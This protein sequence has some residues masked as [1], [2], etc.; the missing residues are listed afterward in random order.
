VFKMIRT[1]A[2]M[3]SIAILFVIAIVAIIYSIVLKGKK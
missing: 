3:I 1:D 2:T